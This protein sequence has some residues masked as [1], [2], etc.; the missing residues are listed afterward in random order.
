MTT[1]ELI[2][3]TL[4]NAFFEKGILTHWLKKEDVAGYE[5]NEYIVFMPVSNVPGVYA[6]D[7]SN[8]RYETFDVKYFA[9][10]EFYN[11]DNIQEIESVLKS[12][13]FY[14]PNGIISIPMTEDDRIGV[15]IEV[16]RMVVYG[17]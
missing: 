11:E 7:I 4:D 9:L 5:Q 13:G 3:E 1:K 2:Q 16:Q 10:K 17:D 15:V 6:N 14:I 12:A 8:M